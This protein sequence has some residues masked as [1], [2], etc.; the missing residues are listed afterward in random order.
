LFAQASAPE[1]ASAPAKHKLAQKYKAAKARH[2][3]A[4][5]TNP[6]TAPDKK[7]GN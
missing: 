6:E 4:S 1:G 2:P 5:A 7:G 3:P